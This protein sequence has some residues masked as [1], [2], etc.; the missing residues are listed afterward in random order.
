MRV[1]CAVCSQDQDKRWFKVR[2]EDGDE[3]EC[4]LA[5]LST[6]LKEEPSSAPAPAP[7]AAAAAAATPAAAARPSIVEAVPVTDYHSQLHDVGYTLIPEAFAQFEKHRDE[8][9]Q[10]F[11]T[12]RREFV[13]QML[14]DA[15]SDD[16]S[17]DR[18]RLQA[19]LVGDV[20]KEILATLQSELERADLH[21]GQHTIN[22]LVALKSLP[23]CAQ[24][25]CHTDLDTDLLADCTTETMPLLVL[26]ALDRGTT[27]QVWPKGQASPILLDLPQ[28]S[29]LVFRADLQHAG[30]AYGISNV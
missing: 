19:A 28:Y 21:I 24:Q 22:T 16:T 5:E 17:G 14:P 15:T 25:P 3:E 23:G 4:S 6:I 9:E 18:R 10:A 2:Y 26:V 1:L 8:I 12:S 30:S 13:F 7:G 29:A 11:G 27:L 20:G